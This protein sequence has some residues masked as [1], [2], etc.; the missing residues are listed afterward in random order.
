[1][2]ASSKTVAQS[3]PNFIPEWICWLLVESL[4]SREGTRRCGWTKL[5]EQLCPAE[6]CSTVFPLLVR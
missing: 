5:V 4:R 3:G 1:M 2:V 6:S